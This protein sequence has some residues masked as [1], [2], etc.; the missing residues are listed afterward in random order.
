MRVMHRLGQTQTGMASYLGISPPELRSLLR[1]DHES[2][3][4]FT[5]PSGI[6]LARK[7]E[8]FT[9]K[10]VTRLFPGV[11]SCT[12]ERER[13]IDL[14]HDVPARL[15]EEASVLHSSPLPPDEACMRNEEAAGIRK[16]LACALRMLSRSDRRIV[17][18]WFLKERTE[19]QCAQALRVSYTCACNRKKHALS[20]LRT[21][22]HLK[23][24]REFL[25]A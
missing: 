11:P 13:S 10:P 7:L 18:L 5:T 20:R 4:K 23:L 16:A 9:G 6:E 1:R 8:E 2:M 14:T 19:R 25:P 15:L 3:P 24:M 17:F 21:P 12:F 22:K